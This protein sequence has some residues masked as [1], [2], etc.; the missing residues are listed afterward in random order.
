MNFTTKLHTN[1]NNFQNLDTIPGIKEVSDEAA[2]T[3]S[4]GNDAITLFNGGNFNGSS[5]GV[6]NDIGNLRDLDFNDKTSSIKIRQG[7]WQV[8][9]DAGF[10]GDKA[11]LGPGDYTAWEL[12]NKY[13]I[14]SNSI[15]SLNRV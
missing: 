13:G 5:V 1:Q 9:E 14:D 6:N 10:K 15:S 12:K 7:V 4:G 11:R 2:A 8:C 3:C